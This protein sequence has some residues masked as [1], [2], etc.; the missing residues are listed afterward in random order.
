MPVPP[1]HPDAGTIAAHAERRLEAPEAARI[2]EHL[3]SCSGCFDTFAE[4]AR[5]VLEEE[6]AVLPRRAKVL[7]FVTRPAFRVAASLAVAVGLLVAF[8]QLWRPHLQGP[9]EPLVADLA[10]AMGE[11]RFIEPRL[12][13]G[14][15]H[16]RHVVLRSGGSDKPQGLDAHS[17]AVL[18]AV[19]RIRERAEGDTSPE[20]LSALAATYLVSGDVG[21]AVKELE[22]ATAQDPKNASLLSDL[23]AAYLVRAS[24]LDE[25]A[26]IPKALE[27]AETAIA[28]EGAP[29][30]AWFNR[31]LALEQLH[32][33]DSAK[34]A[35]EDFLERDSTSPW[36]DEARKHLEELPPA[37]QSTLE[38]DRACARAAI[39]E[40][41][42][43]VD[44][45]ADESPSILADYF[46]A[47]LLPA[48]SDA[49]L[50]G[51]PSAPV[52]RTQAQQV[53][54][55]IFRTTSDAL[56]R[57]AALALAAP[58]SGPSRDRPQVQA[59]GYRALQEAQ[60]L[61]ELGKPACE[62]FR[63]S[64]RLLQEGRSP[65][66]EWARER[67]LVTCVNPVRGPEV[68]AEAAWL[69]GV[70]RQKGY[71]RLLGRALW[72]RALYHSDGGD[73][74]RALSDYRLA[75]DLYHS[76]RDTENETAVLLRLAV[77]LS[78]S[79]D[80]RAAWRA[81]IRAL[82]ALDAT[83]QAMRREE[84]LFMVA[85]ASW[86][87]RL[88]R[89]AVPALTEFVDSVRSRGNAE[90]LA[91]AFVWRGDVYHALGE[92][93]R[94][95]ADL[96]AAR[97]ILAQPGA[98]ANA[99]MGSASAD[100]AEGRIL[101]ESQPERALSSL[102][103]AIPYFERMIPAWAPALHLQAARLLR[104][105]GS[106]SEAEAELETAI[107]QTELQRASLA[108]AQHQALFFDYAAPM[109][110]DEMVSLQ[111]DAHDDPIRALHYVERSR[112]GQVTTA[113]AKQ[114]L[115]LEA[116]QARLPAGT[117]LV[118]YV[119]L[120]DRLVAWVV[121]RTSARCV[122]LAVAPDDLRHRVAAHDAALQGMAA[123]PRLDE[124]SARLFD[125]VIRP[126]LP[127]LR[128]H[129]S[130]AFVPD[131]F[132]RTLSFA[133]LRDRH[134][135]RHLVEDYRLAQ[136]PNGTVLVVASAAASRRTRRDR[137][138]LLAVGDPGLES[139]SGLPDLQGA[140][141]EAT[142]ISRLYADSELLLDTAATKR[143]FFA[144]LER[145]DVVHFAGHATEGD[146]P[147]SGRLLLGAD[148]ETDADGVLRPDEILSRRLGRTRLVVL[149]GCRTA[150]GSRSGFEGALG[151]ARPFLGAGVPM[152]VAS[153]WDVD[154]SASRSFF[155]EFHRRFLAGGDAATAV[156]E[157]QLASLR[158]KDPVLS[159]PAR[160][161]GFVSLGGL[162]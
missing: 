146:G 136:S 118:Y 159:H 123:V 162:M 58:P 57:D 52:L 25:P 116:L 138:R 46:L 78:A 108:A 49:Y 56:P 144:S 135:G 69:E 151:A 139:R 5:F 71:G 102:R 34:K 64:R 91:Y 155:L 74:D 137:P 160:W 157:A 60:R 150:M 3:A 45:L 77:V 90:R 33:V 17:P 53:G 7:P 152:V 119:V 30:E 76:L 37:Q 92:H 19:A 104:T 59:L 70:A 62:G 81:R 79:G 134:T 65:F 124:E 9:R 128:G 133:S 73:F 1:A 14:F 130:L 156:R 86:Q 68:L 27:A 41:Q 48:W 95:V 12:T 82:G 87:E 106:V 63:Q 105:S 51:H 6:D 72:T 35:W 111:L 40:G 29:P 23:A 98:S 145:S 109:P 129:D 47:E 28:I 39:A 18:A 83:K 114:P 154:D 93:E 13:G 84:A 153:L 20:A 126:L 100:A 66:A 127:A 99:D 113:L 120:H 4:T 149:A 97:S 8:Q 96:A 55:A 31:A 131:A 122:Q 88:V 158:G 75:G 112:G 38:E 26:D 132:L 143:A 117:A 11:T 15:Q 142:E 42:A 101:A 44:A 125:D 36:A 94:A 21:Q 32:L 121:D 22:S 16:G 24:R 148:P 103:R 10:R 80:T 141:A 110:F 54:E 61:Y 85:V 89:G 2:D 140:R 107:R 67:V 50:T 43:A 115:A 161:A 147:G